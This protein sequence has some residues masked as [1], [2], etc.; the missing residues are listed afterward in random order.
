MFVAHKNFVAVHHGL[1]APSNNHLA[2][3]MALDLYLHF[4][5]PVSDRPCQWMVAVLFSRR[6]CTYQFMLGDFFVM[7]YDAFNL[8]LRTGDCT[9]LVKTD[10]IRFAHFLKIEA[11]LDQDIFSG[12]IGNGCADGCGSGKN[13]GAGTRHHQKNSQHPVNALSHDQGSR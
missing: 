5:C 12:S 3:C 13:C 7:N 1:H 2:G 11:A 10:N 8:G 9:G 6:G 4:L